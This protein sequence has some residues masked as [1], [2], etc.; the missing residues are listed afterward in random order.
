M[1]TL[2]PLH[3]EQLTGAVGSHPEACPSEALQ[4]QV[5]FPSSEKLHL[6]EEA[7]LSRPHFAGSTLIFLDKCF[8]TIF[9]EIQPVHMV[10]YAS[11]KAEIAPIPLVEVC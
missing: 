11:H 10:R 1:A 8:F 5:M 7:R 2:K 9:A 4:S 3:H 6:H